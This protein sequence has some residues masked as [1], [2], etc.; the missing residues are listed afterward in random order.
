MGPARQTR[1]AHDLLSTEVRERSGRS[2]HAIADAENGKTNILESHADFLFAE[3]ERNGH[4]VPEEARTAVARRLGPAPARRRIVPIT[5]TM[6]DIENGSEAQQGGRWLQLFRET[7][8]YTLIRVGAETGYSPQAIARA[9]R[10]RTDIHQAH[11]DFLF[12]EIERNGHDVPEE[13]RIAVARRIRET[14]IEGADSPMGMITGQPIPPG[15]RAVTGMTGSGVAAGDP[16][17]APPAPAVRPAV[18]HDPD[19]GHDPDTPGTPHAPG[20]QGPD[21]SRRQG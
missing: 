9:E 3:M 21:D 14:E 6:A 20:H 15:G 5:V 16:T 10:S 17:V 8:G 19:E 11:A 7:L 12:A 13:A 1:E 2:R 4:N 18:T